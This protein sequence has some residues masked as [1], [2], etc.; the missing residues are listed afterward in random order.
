VS[1]ICYSGK[2]LNFVINGFFYFEILV[3]PDTRTI[4]GCGYDESNYKV[5][6]TWVLGHQILNLK[7]VKNL[8][9]TNQK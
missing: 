8:K 6:F 4:R 2:I 3:P 7:S 1:L 9:S 5:G